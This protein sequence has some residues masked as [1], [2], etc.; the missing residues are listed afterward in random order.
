MCQRRSWTD[1]PRSHFSLSVLFVFFLIPLF[2]SVLDTGDVQALIYWQNN[3]GTATGSDWQNGG[4][5]KGLFGDPIF[6]DGNTLHFSPANFLAQSINGI[7][8]VKSDRLQTDIQKK[9]LSDSISIHIIPELITIC[10]FGFGD[11]SLIRTK[12]NINK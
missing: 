9:M 4:S 10:V 7:S 1:I 8:T 5:G 12:N 11:L 2:Q 3:N 6:V